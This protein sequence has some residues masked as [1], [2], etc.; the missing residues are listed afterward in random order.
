MLIFLIVLQQLS[1][2]A[3]INLDETVIKDLLIY[4]KSL[5]FEALSIEDQLVLLDAFLTMG[6]ESDAKKLEAY[7]W[8]KL[9]LKFPFLKQYSYLNQDVFASQFIDH[10]QSNVPLYYLLKYKNRFFPSLR[11]DVMCNDIRRVVKKPFD[12]LSLIYIY[13]EVCD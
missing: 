7:I 5:S 8:P 12:Q 1:N 2:M 13:K 9:N 3:K 11:F 10:Y 4:L 6:L